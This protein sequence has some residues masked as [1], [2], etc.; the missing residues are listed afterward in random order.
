VKPNSRKREVLPQADGTYVV[1]VNV[2]PIEGRANQQVVEL[3]ADHFGRTK[4]SITIL[5]GI[6]GKLKVVEID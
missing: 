1:C 3:L 6:R 2:P 5:K 4:R